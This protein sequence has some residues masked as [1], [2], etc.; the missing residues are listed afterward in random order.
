M[1]TPV[2]HRVQ[3]R[4]GLLSD[5][6]STSLGFFAAIGDDIAADYALDG[7]D[8]L[9]FTIPLTD[10]LAPLL[11]TRQ[12]VRLIFTDGSFQ[13]W[14]IEDLVTTTGDGDHTVRI[15][16]S[17]VLLVLADAT[18]MEQV[19]ATGRAILAGSYTG[20]LTQFWDNVLL[21]IL[22][23]AGLTTVDRGTIEATEV[24][25]FEWQFGDTPLTMC[26]RAAEITKTELRIRRVGVTGYLVDWLTRINGGL[27]EATIRARKNLR[28]LQHTESAREQASILYVQGARDS[29]DTPT[30][31]ERVGWLVT[32]VNSGT[33]RLTLGSPLGGIGPLIEDDQLTGYALLRRKTGRLFPVL[34]CVAATQ[35]VEL[36]DLS[37]FA[38]GEYVE[39]RED[40]TTAIATHVYGTGRA[41]L[42]VTA[43][44]GTS[45]TVDSPV[46]NADP[47]TADGQS[48]DWLARVSQ[49][50][51]TTAGTGSVNAF[52]A[53][54]TME[55]LSVTGVQVGD[56]G[57]VVTSASIPWNA[58]NFWAIF[59]VTAVDTVN[60]VL[61]TEVRYLRPPG[62][63]FSSQQSTATVRIYRERGVQPLI[64]AS[65]A[66]TNVLTVASGTSIAVD[67]AIERI[68][69]TGGRQVS[70][71]MSPAAIAALGRKVGTFERHE[72]QGD[73]VLNANPV[74]NTWTGA[75][76]VMP[77]GWASTAGTIARVTGGDYG[78]Y[79]IDLTPVANEIRIATPVTPFPAGFGQGRA[80]VV[81]VFTL[82]MTGNWNSYS[83]AR[84]D[85]SL[86]FG[87]E[88]IGN[89]PTGRTVTVWGPAVT[90]LPADSRIARQGDRVTLSLENL[91]LEYTVAASAGVRGSLFATRD[92]V[93][94]GIWIF[95]S[96]RAPTALTEHGR[97]TQLWQQASIRLQEVAAP[98][99]FDLQVLDIAAIDSVTY[100][101]AD[102]EIGRALRLIDPESQTARSGLRLL[103]KRVYFK[104]PEQNR[105]VVSTRPRTFFEMLSGARVSFQGDVSYARRTDR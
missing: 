51:L 23:D 6:S 105:L 31:I 102:L 62:G 96:L 64:T 14:F 68:Q 41:F 78:T 69:L 63:S 94:E 88:T 52:L 92:I 66:A 104:D 97:G 33:S 49:P 71:V 86:L 85:L 28:L 58:A 75:S 72:Y 24:R 81:V 60:K 99:T 8:Q 50:I 47:I 79:A 4:T 84:V 12:V 77:D 74:C 91:D 30:G 10:R 25:T 98:D 65:A 55:L 61:T 95:P 22:Q 76:T 35:E 2:L 89:T 103:Q 1:A 45:I 3:L 15:T 67:D 54:G 44:A 59:T 17:S 57:I 93:V 5:P 32:A 38:V 82:K 56:W 34:A 16:A 43:V 101:Y 80:A 36:A 27:A 48:V 42:R 39:F 46:D 20:T 87:G 9:E 7:S 90:G 53:N 13:E 40:D 100:P 70:R 18:L 19:D 26:R 73:S 21:G 29:G 37:D 11:Q 83:G